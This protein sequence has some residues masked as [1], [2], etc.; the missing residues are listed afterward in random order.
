MA[1]ANHL[2]DSTFTAFGISV[3]RTCPMIGGLNSTIKN[4]VPGMVDGTGI[5]KKDQK[6]PAHFFFCGFSALASWSPGVC[7]E[8]MNCLSIGAIWDRVAFSIIEHDK[9]I[10]P[11][12]I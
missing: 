1:S 11:I 3:R 2:H 7:V 12:K 8:L 9:N 5:G 10:A 6:P 4:D